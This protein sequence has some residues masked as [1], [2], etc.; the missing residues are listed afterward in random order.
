MIISRSGVD[1]TSVPPITSLDDASWQQVL[2]LMEMLETNN[3]YG[4]KHILPDDTI[5]TLSSSSSNLKKEIDT[6]LLIRRPSLIAHHMMSV[7]EKYQFDEYAVGAYSDLSQLNDVIR[8]QSITIRHLIG[9][10]SKRENLEHDLVASMLCQIEDGDSIDM[11][12][13]LHHLI[14]R[15]KLIRPIEQLFEY[16]IRVED[17]VGIAYKMISRSTFIWDRCI[18]LCFLPFRITP[19]ALWDRIEAEF[20][21]RDQSITPEI[22][23][24]M[25]EYDVKSRC[26]Q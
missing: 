7:A 20:A 26:E 3:L 1:V 9:A 22:V 19:Q 24:F 16:D 6:Q 17:W 10:L 18:K 23:A 14:D 5:R 11:T 13:T 2:I 12:Q 25:A 21:S 8:S 15:A 4:F